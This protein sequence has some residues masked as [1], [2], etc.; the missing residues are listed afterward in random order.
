V[1]RGGEIPRFACFFIFACGKNKKVKKLSQFFF[2]AAP[3]R[4][5]KGG[6]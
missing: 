2:G 3:Q 5:I 6:I 4:K 1:K